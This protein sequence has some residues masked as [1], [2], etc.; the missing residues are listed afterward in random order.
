MQSY[1]SY[2]TVNYVPTRLTGADDAV[3]SSPAVFSSR[4][5]KG[6][7]EK[8]RPKLGPR[9]KGHPWISIIVLDDLSF[10]D[11]DGLRQVQRR[12]ASKGVDTIFGSVAR[13]FAVSFNEARPGLFEI[14]HVDAVLV[15]FAARLFD[16]ER[17]SP[18]SR[19]ST[20]IADV[21]RHIV[22][23]NVTTVRV[24]GL[25]RAPLVVSTDDAVGD[26]FKRVVGLRQVFLVAV[27]ICN[28]KRKLVPVFYGIIGQQLLQTFFLFGGVQRQSVAP[29]L[30]YV[31][32]PVGPV[33]YRGVRGWHDAT[34][35]IVFGRK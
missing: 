32:A 18:T 21:A 30:D 5:F 9:H 3:S 19:L 11:S 33:V 23:S 26:V 14:G 31:Q 10:E 22:L 34:E 15:G 17:S 12:F 4:N 7:P 25:E 27:S 8:S 16:V 6:A 29:T 20:R 1:D 13:E 35:C 2:F 24:E 28:V